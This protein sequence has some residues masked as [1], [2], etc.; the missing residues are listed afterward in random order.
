MFTD[1]ISNIEGLNGMERTMLSSMADIF[2]N[3]LPDVLY[4]THY[5]LEEEFGFTAIQWKRF[6]KLKEIDRA[7]EVEVAGI[8]EIAA[9][10]ALARLQSGKAASA[11]IQAAKQLLENSKLLK[12][13]VDQPTRVVITRIPAKKA[14]PDD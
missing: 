13:K 14:I 5:E 11:D 3:N 10:Q 2:E 8:A 6:L 1:I 7:I 4:M 12:Q 9:R